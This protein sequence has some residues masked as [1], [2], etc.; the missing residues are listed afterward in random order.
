LAARTLDGQALTGP[1]TWVLGIKTAVVLAVVLPLGIHHH[2]RR[3]RAT[4]GPPR[5][6]RVEVAGLLAVLVLGSAL[7]AVDPGWGGQVGGADQ[8]LAALL[9]GQVAD[10]AEC[11][12]L[13]VGRSA[14]IRSG[15]A[16]ILVDEGPQAAIDQMAA[17]RQTGALA[18]DCHQVAHDLGQDAVDLLPD[19]GVV[20]NVDA[21][22]CASGYVHGAIEVSL[23]RAGDDV[24][25]ALPTLCAE[26]DDPP[27]SGPHYNC[28]HGLGHGL[29]L[30]D[31]AVLPAALD[32]CRTLEDRWQVR[33]CASGAFME[34]VLAAQQGRP[35]DVDEDDLH[36]P[37]P[38][39]GEDLAGDCYLMQ[40]SHVLWRLG[41]DVAE[42]FDWCDTAEQRYL[43]ACYRSMGRD[44]SGRSGLDVDV[45]LAECALGQP[46]L[47]GA[48]VAGAAANAVYETAG[49]AAA[50][51]L[52]A[53]VTG[54]DR[55]R[56]EAGRDQV[57]ASLGLR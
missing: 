40:T 6:W 55:A 39:V 15:L 43:D 50:D 10:P 3:D 32:L 17:M 13:D 1:F 30:R 36:H 48:C 52:C 28:L 27:Y 53:A 2:R 57:S 14:C 22:V 35:A 18:L 16:A 54:P 45:V 37:C 9:D 19:L 42:T 24:A 38:T 41:G 49:T 12:D 31:G 26:V 8:A 51:A 4:A 11:A 44:I 56:C 29:M 25:Q 34:N 5:T 20:M 23:A 46:E 7:V 47:R 21:A 33:S